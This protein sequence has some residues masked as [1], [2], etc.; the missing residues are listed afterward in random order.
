MPM[1]L[2]ETEQQVLTELV[3]ALRTGFGASEVLLYG[4]AARG[5]LEEGSDIDLL[6]VLPEVNWEIEKRIVALCF[7]AEMALERI[8]STVCFSRAELEN[9]PLRASPLVLNARREGVPL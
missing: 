4:S 2:S 7:H 5:E 1:R 6:V 9:S 3:K 8:I